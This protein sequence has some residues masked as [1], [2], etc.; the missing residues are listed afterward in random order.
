MNMKK[1]TS[2]LLSL[3]AVAS[4]LVSLTGLAAAAGGA[5][6]DENKLKA[7][8]TMLNTNA[9]LPQADQVMKKQL[10]DSFNV[11]SDKI[12]SLLGR[13]MQY[14]DVAAVLAFADKMSGGVTDANINQVMTMRQ[15]KTG[16]SQIAKSLNVDIADVAS[17]VSD[18]EEDAHKS[19]KEALAEGTAAGRGAGGSED[20]SSEDLSGSGAGGTGEGT[21]G[22]EDSMSGGS[23]G[24][25]TDS[26]TTGGTGGGGY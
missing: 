24:G 22:S 10:T 5:S 26:G 9:K 14:G 12:S 4:L 6:K 21:G 20:M 11:K 17:K 25:G 7:E 18:F 13:N 1:I 8:I 15:S 16:W 19:I 23:A 3:L 2:S